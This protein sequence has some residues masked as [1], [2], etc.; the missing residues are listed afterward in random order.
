MEETNPR[1][2]E[3]EMNE[4]YSTKR[5]NLQ[6]LPMNLK[7]PGLCPAAE[8]PVLELDRGRRVEDDPGIGEPDVGVLLARGLGL[9]PI[10]G[11]LC[12]LLAP[13]VGS[14]LTG[15]QGLQSC[16]LLLNWRK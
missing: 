7:S 16:G 6:I 15:C 5:A 12:S 3:S 8:I 1:D 9:V 2:D 10:R 11:G 13:L 4:G 14:L